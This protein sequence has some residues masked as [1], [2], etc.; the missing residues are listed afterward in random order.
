VMPDVGVIGARGRLGSRVVDALDV[1]G[2]HLVLSATTDGWFEEGRADVVID[3]SRPPALPQVV[4]YCAGSGSGLV[5]A[6]SGLSGDDHALLTSLSARVPVVLAPNLAWGHYLQVVAMRAVLST[7]QNSSEWNVVITDRHPTSKREQ[8]S[9]TCNRLGEICRAHG[10]EHPDVQVT[11]AGE[12][13]S[14]H[15]MVLSG[16]GESLTIMHSVSDL[17]AAARGALKAAHWLLSAEPGLWTMQEVWGGHVASPG[18][19]IGSSQP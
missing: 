19:L 16:K 5:E 12:P 7:M 4:E 15:A 2:W 17:V 9:A 10:I 6:V 3:A 14:D 18:G 8:P 13:V 1:A 11:R